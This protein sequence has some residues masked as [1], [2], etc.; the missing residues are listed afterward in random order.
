MLGILLEYI[1]LY[2]SIFDIHNI[3]TFLRTYGS[4]VVFIHISLRYAYGRKQDSHYCTFSKTDRHNNNANKETSNS[5]FLQ[6]PSLG[7]CSYETNRNA[8]RIPRVNREASKQGTQR[9]RVKR[10]S[11]VPD[12]KQIQ[13]CAG[14]QRRRR[15]AT[16]PFP[17]G[18]V[19][20][21]CPNNTSF[22]ARGI[23][24]PSPR[25]CRSSCNSNNN[26]TIAPPSPRIPCGI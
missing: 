23:G 22:T 24:N 11:I 26:N 10:A 2:D 7:K 8:P 21:T 16:G 5:Y 9:Q 13:E 12:E 18:I 17:Q 3:F 20:T 15:A 6:L 4:S 25:S 19:R 1:A 14:Y